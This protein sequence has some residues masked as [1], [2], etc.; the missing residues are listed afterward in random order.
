MASVEAGQA[1][2]EEAAADTPM[3][4]GE[5]V[6]VTIHLSGSVDGV[7][8]FLEENG[9]DPRKRGR[10]LHRSLR[11]ADPA[12]AALGTARRPAGA[13][14]RAAGA[15]AGR[16]ANSRSGRLESA[17]DREHGIGGAGEGVDT[18]RLKSRTKYVAIR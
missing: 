12:G 11:A 15:G 6:A 3:H 9:G 13:G 10:G 1:T 2:A 16:L 17:L 14:N 4:S 7:V 8:A 5:S 18:G